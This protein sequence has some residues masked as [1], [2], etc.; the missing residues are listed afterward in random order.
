[1]TAS[2]D[3]TVRVWDAETGKPLGVMRPHGDAINSVAVSP[4]GRT[5]LTASNDTTAKLTRCETCVPAEAL[6]AVA[7]RRVTR[8]LTDVERQDFVQD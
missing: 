5:F 7:A 8:G 2:T 4:D 6:L 3:K 1:M